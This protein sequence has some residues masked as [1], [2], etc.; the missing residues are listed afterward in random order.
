MQNP[1]HEVGAS[2]CSEASVSP[3][4][5]QLAKVVPGTPL[6]WEQE[7]V[8]VSIYV[9]GADKHGVCQIDSRL[10]NR[11]PDAAYIVHTANA[12]PKLIAALRPFADYALKRAAMPLNGLGD[13]LHAIHIGTEWEAEVTLTQCNAALALLRSLGEL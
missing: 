10:E 9:N 4:S 8:Y 5:G 2:T 6:P 7:R 11:K 12:Y 13:V 3:E 1:V